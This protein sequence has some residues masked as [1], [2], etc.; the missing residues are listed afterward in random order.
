M[1]LDMYL[2]AN[3]YVSRTQRDPQGLSYDTPKRNALFDTLADRRKGWVDE[4]GYQGISISYPVG[5]WRKANAIHN[6]FVQNVQDNRDECQKSYVSPE[7]LRELREAC[8]AVLATRNPDK[9]GYLSN[10]YNHSMRESQMK[11][12]I[13]VAVASAFAVPAFA[14]DYSVNG[15]VEYTYTDSN[16]VQ[17]FDSGDQDVVVSASEELD[18][19]MTVS[20]SLEMDGNEDGLNSDSELTI[21][22]GIVTFRIGDATADAIAMYDAKSMVAEK[23]GEDSVENDENGAGESHAASIEL[24]PAEGLSIAFSMGTDKRVAETAAVA[25]VAGTTNPVT[26][27][28]AQESLDTTSYAVQYSSMGFSVSY[29][30]LDKDGIDA[31]NDQD[32][33]SSVS[34]S[35]ATG[36]FYIGYDSIESFDFDKD[37]EVTVIGASY[38]YGQGKLFVES[39]EQEV[40]DTGAVTETVAIG[41]SYMLGGSVNLYMV[42]NEV[43]TL[44]ATGGATTDDNQTI[45]GVEYAF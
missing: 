44:A 3:E 17:E 26:G 24:S 11:K 18:N 21:S 12:I 13:A 20:V 43:E 27:A 28:I 6:W 39:G 33:Q 15:D 40:K 9:R 8:Q 31:T 14:A 19:G 42:S 2:T 30:V 10:L 22:N 34:A 29:G 1:G 45:I 7:N 16:T 32:S 4:A 41:A 25:Y 23:G 5:Y 35:Y 36:P 38:D 37:N